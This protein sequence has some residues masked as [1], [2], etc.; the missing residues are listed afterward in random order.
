MKKLIWL[1]IY[2]VLS[3]T[4]VNAATIL[5][6]DVATSCERPGDIVFRCGVGS[7]NV[8]LADDFQG[9]PLEQKSAIEFSLSGTT[10]LNTAKLH[11][12]LISNT[13]SYVGIYEIPKIEIH[14]YLGEGTISYSDL[15]TDN[16][17]LTS[18]ELD[19]LGWYVFDVTDFVSSLVAKNQDFAGFAIRNIVPNSQAYFYDSSEVTTKLV[20]SSVPLPASVWLFG[21]GI[22]SLILTTTRRRAA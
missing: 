6:T 21:S 22:F 11:F 12:N 5:H 19:T 8:V 3:C 10:T 4:T 1:L 16:L 9:E 14:G 17:L 13:N 7:V 2:S 15:N 18:Q 20:I